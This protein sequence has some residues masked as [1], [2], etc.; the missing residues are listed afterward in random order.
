VQQG[1]VLEGAD[2]TPFQQWTPI[3][4]WVDAGSR[5]FKL[6]HVVSGL[7]IPNGDNRVGQALKLVACSSPNTYWMTLKVGSGP[8]YPIESK[9]SVY[10][11]D[12]TYI[13]PIKPCSAKWFE[14]YLDV[15]KDSY[16]QGCAVGIWTWEGGASNQFWNFYDSKGNQVT[17][18]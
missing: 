17:N 5:W 6:K 1:L 11:N 10:A 18:I 15:L 9:R 12:C 4:F 2:S 16:C 13:D 14:L 8:A 3:D 7:C